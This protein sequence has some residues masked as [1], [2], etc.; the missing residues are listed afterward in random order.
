MQDEMIDDLKFLND[1]KDGE[2]ILIDDDSL[3][4]IT[5]V[6]EKIKTED[7]SQQPV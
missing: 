5:N 1:F 7:H 3:L 6:A 4:G 2:N